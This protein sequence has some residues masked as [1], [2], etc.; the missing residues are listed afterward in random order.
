MLKKPGSV[1]EIT[2]SLGKIVAQLDSHESAQQQ[3][4]SQH[5]QQ[6]A[7]LTESKNLAA[8]EA[9]KAKAVKEKINALIS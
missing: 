8:E 6:I 1:S 3:M 2:N 5:E 9:A 7:R 4:V